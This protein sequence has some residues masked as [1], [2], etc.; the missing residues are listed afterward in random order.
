MD[1]LDTLSSFG[2]TALEVV[3]V[4]A[5]AISGASAALRHRLDWLTLPILAVVVSIGGGT[6]RDL[7]L[8]VPVSWLDEP[9]PIALATAVGIVVLVLSGYLSERYDSAKGVLI[10]DAG[11]LAVFV[12]LGTD[13]ALESGTSSE[14]AAIVGV[15]T[16]VVGGVTRDVLV[17]EVPV[18]FTGR[19]YALPALIGAGLYV[20]FLELGVSAHAAFWAP[21]LLIL[22]LRIGAIMWDWSVPTARPGRSEEH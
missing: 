1:S 19:L 9:W 4:V 21:V 8:D 12:I 6:L 2:T 14:V 5:F 13:K 22:L 10:A 3:G 20:V 11:G 18:L 15:I 16:G 17:N 7:L